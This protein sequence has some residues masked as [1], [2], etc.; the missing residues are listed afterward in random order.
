MPTLDERYIPGASLPARDAPLARLAHFTVQEQ[1]ASM[2]E[3]LLLR[4]VAIHKS[5]AGVQALAAG[6]YDL[7]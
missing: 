2:T 4:A 1:P 3:P 7:R 5:L 6:S